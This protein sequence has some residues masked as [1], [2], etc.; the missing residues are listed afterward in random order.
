MAGMVASCITSHE[1]YACLGHAG[2]ALLAVLARFLF[3]LLS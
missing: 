2:L 3:V 1:M